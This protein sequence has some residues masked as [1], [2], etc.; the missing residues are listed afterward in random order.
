MQ[1]P[2]LPGNGRRV[3]INALEVYSHLQRQVHLDLHHAQGQAHVSLRAINL[4]KWAHDLFLTQ[5]TT[6]LKVLVIYFPM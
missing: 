6:Y 5:C 4:K 3:S 1:L 2:A